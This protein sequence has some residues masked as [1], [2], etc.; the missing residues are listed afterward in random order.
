MSVCLIE[1]L[2]GLQ[3]SEAGSKLSR[4][5]WETSPLLTRP[6]LLWGSILWAGSENRS[7]W[8]RPHHP[9]AC[10][11]PRTVWAEPGWAA[12]PA[13]KNWDC[14][15]AI[16]DWAVV[17][18]DRCKIQGR[19]HTWQGNCGY[20]PAQLYRSLVSERTGGGSGWTSQQHL[21]AYM[22]A[23]SGGRSA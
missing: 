22:R 10:M 5:T 14:G 11:R 3:S 8:A 23:G 20:S 18:P 2:E 21:S 12:I 4:G 7:G 16:S 1:L 9:P 13:S 17:P 6:Q 19:S 15:W